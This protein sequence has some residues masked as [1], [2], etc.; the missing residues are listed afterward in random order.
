MAYNKLSTLRLICLAQ[1]LKKNSFPNHTRVMAE[2]RR[3][4]TDTTYEINPKTIKR[5]VDF[6]KAEYNAPIQYD[7]H[8][9][10]YYLTDPDWVLD[11][12]AMRENEQEAALISARL[13]EGLL[14]Q[15]V[16]SRI[17][18][19]V[20]VLAGSEGMD[21][22]AAMRSL[23]ASGSRVPIVPTLF[24]VVFQGWRLHQELLLHYSSAWNQRRS[25]LLFEPHVLA[26]YEGGWYLKGRIVQKDGLVC[27]GGQNVVT[28][29]VHRI[30][31]A[32]TTGR[33]FVWDSTIA[34]KAGE[35]GIFDLPKVHN[36]RLKLRGHCAVYG[37]E[38]FPHASKR[39]LKNGD[40]ALT[41]RETEEYR[42]INFVMTSA[43]N[44]IVTAPQEL[45]EKIHSCAE[46]IAAL[47]GTVDDEG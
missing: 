1:M 27:T 17:Q 14:P 2:I 25:R 4:T 18:H 19:S 43:G 16:G 23:M 11:L 29:A 37:Q 44:A 6:L 46:S 31:S 7:L 9:K 45:V 35:D 47:H 22:N 39:T 20:S 33:T 38:L 13:S 21:E 12:S 30:E 5:D 26:F 24:E 36:V 34:D 41:V 28:L 32:V 3:Y 10:G 40:I 8:R 15:P 42:L